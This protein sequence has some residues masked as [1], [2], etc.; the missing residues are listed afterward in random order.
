MGDINLEAFNFKEFLIGLA[1]GG[2]LCGA[3]Y[4]LW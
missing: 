4:W 2:V 3:W 1:I